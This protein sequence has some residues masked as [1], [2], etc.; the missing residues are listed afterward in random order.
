M[1]TTWD[2]VS[3]LDRM[4]DDDMGSA[5]GTATNSRP[6]APAIDVRANENEVVLSCDVPGM[7]ERDL[8]VMLENHVLTI[9]GRRK[10]EAHDDEQVVLGR[11]YGAFQRAFTLRT[12]STRTSSARTSLTACSRYGSR[13][14]RKPSRGE[15][16]SRTR[17]APTSWRSRMDGN[18]GK[19]HVS[20]SPETS[21]ALNYLRKR[22]QHRVWWKS[23]EIALR[24]GP[25]Q[26]R[27]PNGP[28]GLGKRV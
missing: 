15:F 5:F 24:R 8:E 10:F 2:A 26:P 19:K 18:T 22:S 27:H 16:R 20:S 9:K 4:F 3:T 13:R 14:M 6:F 21:A 28:S 17:R 7:K 1:L 25:S 11:A 23:A 12:R